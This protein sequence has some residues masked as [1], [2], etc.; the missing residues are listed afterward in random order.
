MPC[1]CQTKK[2]KRKEPQ[3]G[4]PEYDAYLSELRQKSDHALKNGGSIFGAVLSKF[5]IKKQ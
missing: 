5:V 4:T 2:T 1:I 3:P